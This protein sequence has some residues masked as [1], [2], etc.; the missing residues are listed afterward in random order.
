MLKNCFMFL[1]FI[2]KNRVKSVGYAY[3]VK[4]SNSYI[5]YHASARI[6]KLIIA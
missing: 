2:Y 5:D 4:I 1:L 3:I 6:Y